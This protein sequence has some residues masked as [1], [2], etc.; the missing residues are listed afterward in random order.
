MYDAFKEHI[1]YAFTFFLT[2]DT[3]LNNN[4]KSCY[5]LKKFHFFPQKTRL[6]S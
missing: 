5:E 6:F 1:V 2:G 4:L 3:R